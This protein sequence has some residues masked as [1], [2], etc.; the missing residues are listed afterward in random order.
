MFDRGAARKGGGVR[1]CR[2]FAPC[3]CVA[4]DTVSSEEPHGRRRRFLRRRSPRVFSPSAI[5]RSPVAPS[6]PLLAGRRR[7]RFVR[8]AALGA[9]GSIH[10]HGSTRLL[11][12]LLAKPSELKDN[13]GEQARRRNQVFLKIFHWFVPI[14]VTSP[15]GRKSCFYAL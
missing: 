1:L 12:H 13:S 5:A 6:R 7:R 4:P 11:M 2:R 9:R 8:R 3:C 15:L 10:R 14:L